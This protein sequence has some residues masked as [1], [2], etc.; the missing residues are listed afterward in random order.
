MSASVLVVD[1]LPFM[2]TVIR[3]ILDDAG[4]T[5]VAEAADGRQ[6][7]VAYLAVEPD[8]VLL[9]IAMPVMD[10]IT[11]LRKLRSL[12]PYSRV[13]MC[14]AMGEQEM[15]VKA[16]QLGATDFVVK[17]FKRERIVGAITRALERGA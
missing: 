4:L 11:T 16:I 5:V 13:I 6:A 2:R 7:L 14:S 9:D 8:I 12:D 1:D 17:P 3:E 10:G 15:I